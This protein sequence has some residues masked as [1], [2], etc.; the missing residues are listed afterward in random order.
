M[1]GRA[2]V[3]FRTFLNQTAA[4]TAAKP[5]KMNPKVLLVE[6][7]PTTRAF[8]HAATRA[9]DVEID[10][11]SSMREALALAD[12]ACYSVFLLDARLPDGSGTELL[13]TL[14]RTHPDTPAL[15]HTAV[16]DPAELQRLRDAGFNAAVSK[17]LSARDWQ[18]AVRALLIQPAAPL[19]DDAA[20][21]KIL[22]GNSDDLDALRGLFVR[23]LQ[24]Q[25]NTLDR[26]HTDQD[27]DTVKSELHRLR[28]SCGFVGAAR[29]AAAI[30][31][32]RFHPEMMTEML[33]TARDTLAAAP[34][35][36]DMEH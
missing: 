9:L 5:E 31:H 10:L 11:A 33:N 17:P 22:G 32:W 21:L 14:R 30:E 18:A 16:T 24:G 34:L 2:I 3:S 8:L 13:T 29:L 15:A 19:W 26:A 7:D 20:A 28:A 35:C 1:A 27:D 6:D 4:K 36:G 25:I 12:A 23:E